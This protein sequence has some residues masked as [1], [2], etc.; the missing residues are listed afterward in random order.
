M[1]AGDISIPLSNV[2]CDSGA[3]YSSY[4]SRDLV[5]K[6]REVLKDYIRQVNSKVRLGDHDTIIEVDE[7]LTIPVTFIDMDFAEHRHLVKFVVFPMPHLDC[8]IGLPELVGPFF[9]YFFKLLMESRKVV[10]DPTRFD[11]LELL[12]GDL[13]DPWPTPLDDPAP[14]D[15]EIELPCM[16]SHALQY[17]GMPW[18]DA[19]AE[20][21][22]S[23]SKQVNA[24]ML[25]A[26]PQL[27]ELLDTVGLDVFVK[28]K[29]TGI[30]GIEPI[31]LKFRE[32]MPKA[33]KPQYRMVNRKL[34]ENA[35]AE[36]LRLKEYH[37]VDSVSPVCSPMVV[38]PKNT[39]P[40]IRIALDSR[41]VNEYIETQH[42][43]IPNP[44][45]E[46]AK[47]AQFKVFIDVDMKNSF[48]QFR[49]AEHTSNMLSMQTPWGQ[50]RPLFMPE[51]ITPAS[52]I[53]QRA[54]MSMFSDMDS[55]SAIIFDNI[56]IGAY[57]YEDGYVKFAKF[58]YRCKDRDVA[59][60]FSKSF[61]GNDYA[62]FFGYHVR[63]GSWSITPARIRS[64]QEIPI[65][66]TMVQLR[67]L[68]GAAV[69]VRNFIPDFSA[70]TAPLHEC[71][72]STFKW[73][74]ETVGR[75]EAQVKRLKEAVVNAFTL[76]F[77]DFELE[78][79]LMADA[80]DWAVASVL[81]QVRI[82]PS[83]DTQ[84]EPLFFFSHKL[85]KQA[86]NWDT[87]KKECWALV[88]AVRDNEYLLRGKEFTFFT[89]HQN[90]LYMIAHTAPII[91]RWR[92]FL[93]SFQFKLKHIKGKLNS[94]ADFGS[95]M[96]LQLLTGSEDSLSEDDIYFLLNALD[97]PPDPTTVENIPNTSETVK[98]LFSKVHG[99]KIG[100]WGLRHTYKLLN[101]FYPGHGI[102]L[103][104]LDE[105]INA[106]A[107]CQKHR[108]GM[109]D[110]LSG[111]V[112]HL[113]QSG[114]RDTIAIDTLTV[115]PRDDFGN[116][117]IIVI[118]NLFDK[119]AVLYPTSDKEAETTANCLLQYFAN[120]G[121]V[122]SLHSDPGSDFTSQVVTELTKSFGITQSF[123]IV[124]HPQANGVEGSNAQIIRHLIAMVMDLRTYNKWS[125]PTILSVI[126]FFLNS[127]DNSE[128]GAIPFELRFGSKDLSHFI[129]PDT[130]SGKSDYIKRLDSDLAEI[131]RRS[132]EYQQQL[133]KSKTGVNPEAVNR[134]QAGDY[135]LL[136]ALFDGSLK[137]FK[138]K[139]RY[140]GPY[141][142]IKQYKNDVEVR[143]LVEDSVHTFVVDTLK[144]FFGND[145]EAF[146][147]ALIDF[148]RFIV[149]SIL[150]Y[151][152]DPLLRSKCDFLVQYE[153]D[154]KAWLSYNHKEIG[155]L[156]AFENY[157]RA[158]PALFPLLFSSV[159][160]NKEVNRLKKIEIN[161]YAVK[162]SIFINI[163]FFG[164]PFISDARLTL[165]DKYS[166]TY[167][168]A[169]I[170]KA[171]L[172]RNKVME[173]YI[174]LLKLTYHLNGYDIKSFVSKVLKANETLIDQALLK[175][176][177]IIFKIIPK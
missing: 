87:L 101:K 69:F 90:L 148:N 112:R 125:H 109:N 155:S 167:R 138:L 26:C 140:L 115:T 37:L 53:L 171:F 73:D 107:I 8:I 146:R 81:F 157:C 152:G 150:G 123:T 118:I 42:T 44:Q 96:V 139:H 160:A 55:Y 13:I 159:D 54:V 168:I 99:G 102:P 24:D 14:E 45:Q 89:D 83:G 169:A 88:C 23:Y 19:V 111:I 121:V 6:Y 70:I 10:E 162:E 2:L 95:R 79:V 29:W 15:D 175:K 36:F 66:Q 65:P 80:S 52:S 27:I 78:W 39:A 60:K 77:P 136:D 108:L 129:L 57:D 85:S 132:I 56:L 3:L 124:N 72:T 163:R 17:L 119:L 7:E 117:Y 18:E 113:H 127:F 166:I 35:H 103:R 134:Y 142:V 116:Q 30:S 25:K 164:A 47:M 128:T 149:K 64:I 114:P 59:L 41:K 22:A 40:F 58:L 74:S 106:C 50:V 28:K 130:A 176:N 31:E 68:L 161:N 38:A 16:F 137:E 174:P 48:H 93:Q 71:C 154:T 105:L 33:M 141:Q 62:D 170:V 82:L 76:F 91:I 86:R 20:Y 1:H 46:I 145:E 12:E 173:I 21:K 122:N 104:V 43:Y 94:F 153:S 84:L 63:N 144:P 158:H 143:H 135:V 151:S 92:V 61:I 97:V 120:Y 75:I 32:D 9:S 98:S 147:A 126:Q 49:L 100:H 11:R 67:S 133:I 5:N 172:E 177:P 131:R 165:Q 156:L 51:G 34:L 4:F 110:R